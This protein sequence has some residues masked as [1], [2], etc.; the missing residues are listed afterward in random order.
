MNALIG[1][2]ILLFILYQL[3]LITRYIIRRVAYQPYTFTHCPT[4]GARLPEHIPACAWKPPQKPRPPIFAFVTLFICLIPILLGIYF[5]F[6]PASRPPSTQTPAPT[7]TLKPYNLTFNAFYA[8]PTRPAS[9][10]SCLLWSQVTSTMAGKTLCVYGTVTAVYPTDETSTRIKFSD[11]PNTFFIYSAPYIF[12]D[13]QTNA[14]LTVGDCVMLTSSVQL[15][16]NIPYMDIRDS[17][18]YHCP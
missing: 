16:Q 18:L 17:T 4:C 14:P 8:N 3:W 7:I 1:L 6:L 15:Y 9:T 5:E 11:Q 13:E 2:F 12:T 10:T